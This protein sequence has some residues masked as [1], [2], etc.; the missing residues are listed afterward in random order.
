MGVETLSSA[1][2]S[3]V[4]T[5]EVPSADVSWPGTRGCSYSLF[6]VSME[7]GAAGPVCHL[8]PGST[9]CP[10][11]N[12]IVRNNKRQTPTKGITMIG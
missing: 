5:D 2:G 4:F 8:P 9:P 7:P 11:R 6:S 12:L 1:F 10:V 3:F